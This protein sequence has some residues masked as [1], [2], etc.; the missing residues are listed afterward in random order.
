MEVKKFIFD[1]FKDFLKDMKR[2][3]LK[4]VVTKKKQYSF[5][6]FKCILIFTNEIALVC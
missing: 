5:I 4:K 3:R 1:I 2:E 6:V